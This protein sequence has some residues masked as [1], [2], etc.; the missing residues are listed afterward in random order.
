MLMCDFISSSSK[1]SLLNGMK[2]LW[3]LKI[4]WEMGYRRAKIK[5]DFISQCEVWHLCLNIQRDTF[6]KNN[7]DPDQTSPSWSVWSESTL[8]AHS[9]SSFHKVS[10]DLR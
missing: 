9:V 3:D 5:W 2:I 8:F 1:R 7:V 6:E 10:E 4:L